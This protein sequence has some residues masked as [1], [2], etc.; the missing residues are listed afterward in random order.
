MA[1][2][3]A[4]ARIGIGTPQ[5]NPT[6]EP[7]LGI[8]MPRDAALYATRLTSREARPEDRLQAYI[9]NLDASLETYDGLRL[10]AFGFACTG[11]SYL[12]GAEEERRLVDAASA[13][14]GYPVVT[15]ADAIAWSLARIGARRIAVI[16][17]YPDALIAASQRYFEGRG[18]QIVAASRVVTRTSDTR[19]IYELTPDQARG[20]LTASAGDA[21]AVLVSGTGMASLSLLEPEAD[22]P[23][24]SSNLCL[25]ARLLDAVGRA[26]LL[27]G[28]APRG[29]RRR[30]A[31]ALPA[32]P[33]Q[34]V[35]PS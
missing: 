10:S 8:L 18:L 6:V 7:E 35:A 34:E 28:A 14:F 19:S 20:L 33:L 9:A 30:L 3:G 17:P 2:Y 24:L 22:R 11:S 12:V 32:H 16:A 13:R 26:D 5:S 31:E 23:I 15:A 29:W 21:D 1:V 25:S 4:V 27:D